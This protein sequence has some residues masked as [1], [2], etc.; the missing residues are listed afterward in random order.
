MFG[1]EKTLHTGDL[2]VQGQGIGEIS[3]LS[4]QFCWQ[5][6][7]AIKKKSVKNPFSLSLFSVSLILTCA[8]AYLCTFLVSGS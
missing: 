3:V 2:S 8:Q 4:A 1:N 6:K 7:T 5:P